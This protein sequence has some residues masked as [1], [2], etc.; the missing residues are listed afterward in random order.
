M[1]GSVGLLA[2]LG[3]PTDLPKTLPAGSNHARDG[4]DSQVDPREDDL[5]GIDPLPADEL[6]PA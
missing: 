4:P 5:L 6:Q 3:L 2:H 1:T